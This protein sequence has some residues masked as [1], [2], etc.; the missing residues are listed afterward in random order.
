MGRWE[1]LWWVGPD[2]HIRVV[3]VRGGVVYD[4]ANSKM[5]WI[6]V[7]KT[8]FRLF[9]TEPGLLHTVFRGRIRPFRIAWLPYYV[10][11]VRHVLAEAFCS[12]IARVAHVHCACKCAI[13]SRNCSIVRELVHRPKEQSSWST[14]ENHLVRTHENDSD[15]EHDCL[16]ERLTCC[17]VRIWWVDSGT[18][19]K[20][21]WWSLPADVYYSYK[22]VH[23]WKFGHR[24]IRSISS[25]SSYSS[26]IPL[27]EEMDLGYERWQVQGAG[28]AQLTHGNVTTLLKH[29]K[30]NATLH[31]LPVTCRPMLIVS[32]AAYNLCC[33][34]VTSLKLGHVLSSCMNHMVA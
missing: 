2:P 26:S 12:P 31:V 16:R 11:T 5:D 22:T 15:V 32:P 28:R 13:A 19:N 1:I 6:N 8:Y 7:I 23:V 29:V 27:Q 18:K 14:I 4:Q 10:S 25:S 3:T 21:D 24:S 9:M 33:M 20:S 34:C 17:G 30:A